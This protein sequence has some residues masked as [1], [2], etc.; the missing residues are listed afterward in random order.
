M[1]IHAFKTK[2]TFARVLQQFEERSDVLLDALLLARD[3]T[4]DLDADE[5]RAVFTL[6]DAQ[7]DLVFIHF[8]DDWYLL[9]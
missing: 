3:Q 6:S 5:N 1:Q 8:G 2:G 9:N 7:P 4:P